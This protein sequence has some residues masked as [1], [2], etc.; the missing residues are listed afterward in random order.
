[1]VGGNAIHVFGLLGHAAKKISAAHHN[2]SLN[3]EFLDV[4]ELGSD[5][6][7]ARRVHTK[8]LVCGQSFSGYF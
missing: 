8:A 4:A 7:N 2:R 6:V 3:P 5:L 1:M